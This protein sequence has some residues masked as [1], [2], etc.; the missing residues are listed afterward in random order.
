M[1]NKTVLLPI[2]NWTPLEYLHGFFVVNVFLTEYIF[3]GT[4][5][6]SYLTPVN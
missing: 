1:K 3:F 5:P 2:N 4:I 6:F